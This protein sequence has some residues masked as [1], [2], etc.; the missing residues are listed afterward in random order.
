MA[1]VTFNTVAHGQ[2]SGINDERNVVI[3]GAP[4]W[5][6]LW[7]QH[8][9]NCTPPPPAVDVDFESSM[10]ICV[11]LGTRSSGGYGVEVKSISDTGEELLVKYEVSFPTGMVTMALTQPHHIVRVA[12]SEKPVKFEGG[13][14]P[15]P[16]RP[17]KFMLTFK[18]DA[19]K[20]DVLAKVNALDLVTGVKLLTGVGIGLVDVTGETSV[21]Q[22]AL[23]AVEGVKTVELD[24]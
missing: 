6:E 17:S 24:G 21:A 2:R 15:P 5:E 11:C 13:A 4:E 18:K 7:R 14:A 3:K 23:E 9:S 8:G 19:D 22:A 16:I 1:A 12:R 10:L 20:D